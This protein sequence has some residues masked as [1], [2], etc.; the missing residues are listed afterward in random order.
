[1]TNNSADTGNAKERKSNEG[2]KLDHVGFVFVCN[3]QRIN[4]YASKLL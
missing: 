1:M 2:D 3:N 4:K